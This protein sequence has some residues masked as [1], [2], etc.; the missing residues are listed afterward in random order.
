MEVQVFQSYLDKYHDTLAQIQ[1]DAHDLHDSVNQTYGK[2]LPYGYHLDHVAAAAVKYGHF[3]CQDERDVLPIIF[4]A[5]Y[6]D[7][8][9]DARYTYHDIQ[10]AAR[11]YMAEE[12]VTM[13]AEIVYALTNEKGR[14]REERANERYY[15]GIRTTPYAP[16]IKLCDR[17][18]NVAFS[19][20]S[21]DE[22]NV[23][24]KKI[25]AQEMPHFIEA[26]R[27]KLTDSRLQLPEE[28]ISDLLAILH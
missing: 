12:Q 5:Y 4:G 7:S 19:V 28:M 3:V 14:T 27:S 25:Y 8:I 22:N 10:R 21:N 26:I 20:Q 2:N 24:M 11:P 6:H 17:Y 1:Q 15:A 16:F 23:R 9:E 18:A 13:A